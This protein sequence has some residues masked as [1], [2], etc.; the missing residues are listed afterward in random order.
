A[1]SRSLEYRDHMGLRFV[2][3]PSGLWPPRT[4]GLGREMERQDGFWITETPVTVGAYA[5]L[6]PTALVGRGARHW[7]VVD[8]DWHSATEYCKSIG[9][10]LPT[11]NEWEYAASG[12]LVGCLYPWGNQISPA[13]ALY[14]LRGAFPWRKLMR[15]F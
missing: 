6:K 5:M 15:K 7:P 2:R 12:G 11:E 1:T 4:A 9:A 13:H 14:D 8:V 10:R 3:I